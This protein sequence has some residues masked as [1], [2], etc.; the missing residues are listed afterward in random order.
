MAVGQTIHRQ[1][2]LPAGNGAPAGGGVLKKLSPTAAGA[3]RLATRY[4][5]SLVCV[6]YREDPVR[7]R[8]LTTV[9][10]IVDERPLPPS[11]AVR[12]AFG[13][14]ELRNAVKAAGGTWDA[15]RKLWLLSRAAVRKLKLAHRVVTEKA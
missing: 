15:R 14:T 6:R 10:L 11:L 1:M 4:G 3:K 9:E 13:E 7:G 12:V 5:Q 8:R 2:T